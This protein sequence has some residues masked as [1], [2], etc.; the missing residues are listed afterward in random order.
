MAERVVGPDPSPLLMDGDVLYPSAAPGHSEPHDPPPRGSA[1]Q[2]AD[3]R[4]TSGRLG[5]ASGLMKRARDGAVEAAQQVSD[6]LE[7]LNVLIAKRVN[8]LEPNLLAPAR[9][10]ARLLREEFG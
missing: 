3:M 4:P 5:G 6:R 8:D 2:L 7:V 1:A 9:P 10:R